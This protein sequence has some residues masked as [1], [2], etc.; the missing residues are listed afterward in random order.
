MNSITYQKNGEY[1]IPNL[2]ITSPEKSLGKYGRMRK[3]YLQYHRTAM[4][5]SL[6]LSEKLY[7]H[8]LEIDQTAT[9]RMEQIMTDLQKTQ[10]PPDK[11]TQ[12]M[13]W[14]GYMNNLKAQAEEIILSELIYN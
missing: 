1:Q 6:L 14:V 2:S 9:R 10:T 11:M 5:N 12:Q 7:H 3:A 4:F 13:Q 8:L